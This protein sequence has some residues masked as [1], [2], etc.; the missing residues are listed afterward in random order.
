MDDWE[1]NDGVADD[2]VTEIFLKRRIGDIVGRVKKDG[3]IG[4]SIAI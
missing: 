2:G 3:E 4:I 1:T